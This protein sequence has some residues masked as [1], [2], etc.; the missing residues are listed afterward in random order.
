MIGAPLTRLWRPIAL[1]LVGLG[2]ATLGIGVWRSPERTWPNVLLANIYVLS[3]ALASAVFIAMHYLSG[4]GWWVA[5]RR[6]AEAA[7]S[8]LPILALPMP[9]IFIGRHAIYRWT[10]AA[11]GHTAFAPAKAV[12]LATPFVLV[13][14]VAVLGAWVWLVH[15]LRRTSLQQDDDPSPIHHRRMVRYSAVFVVVFAFSFS[16][17]SVDWLM[18]I[19]PQWSSTMFAVY[20]FAGLLAAGLA[21]LTLI[22]LALRAHGPLRTIVTDAHLHDLGTL[23]FAFSTFWAY[24]WLSQ[25]L[26]IWYGNLPEEVTPYVRRTAG[27]WL[28]VFLLNPILNWAA[29]FL[30]LIRWR[31]KHHVGVL[32]A[33]CLLLVVGH[34]LDL[35]LLIM[36]DL[37]AAPALGVQET[38]IPL[39]YAGLFL[40][41]TS[42]ALARA[43][44]LP[45]H[46][47]FLEESLHHEV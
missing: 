26:L 46:D 17:A 11:A 42:R 45:P 35:Y 12:Y 37:F 21:V 9:A 3:V 33:A 16:L 24:I 1:T 2:L 7:M 29:P 39:G 34:W 22:V 19:D 5:V 15:K 30:L 40:V 10:D 23:L 8:S 18:A 4:A 27:A 6:V 13:R 32:T 20:V 25:Y 43:P 14:T 31:A 28:P 36:P 44:V 41:L 38:F 47:P